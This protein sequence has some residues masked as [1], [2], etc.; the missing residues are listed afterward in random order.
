[1]CL[2][3]PMQIK[4]LRCDKALA[5]LRGVEREVSLM[6]IEEVSVGDYVLVHAGFAISVIDEETAEETVALLEEKYAD[7]AEDGMAEEA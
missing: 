1:M 4:E 5:E 2:G 6:L 3:V 7:K